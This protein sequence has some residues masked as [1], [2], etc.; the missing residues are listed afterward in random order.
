MYTDPRDQVNE[1]NASEFYCP[2]CRTEQSKPIPFSIILPNDA[3]YFDMY[4][5]YTWI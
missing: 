1:I 4:D 3:I 5:F 2:F